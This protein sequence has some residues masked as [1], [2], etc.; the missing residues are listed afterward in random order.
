MD[1]IRETFFQ[2]CEEQ[3]D[4]LERGLLAMQEGSTDSET[5]NAVFR[6]VH[7]IRGGAGAFQL[8]SLVRFAHSFETTLDMIRNERLAPS[9]AVM[10]TMLRAADVLADLVTEARGSGDVDPARS[11]EIIA[12]LTGHTGSA[13]HEPS[14]DA[15]SSANPFAQLGFNPVALSFDSPDERARAKRV[16]ALQTNFRRW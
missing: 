10:R 14:A 4:E 6:A 15:S 1:V 8:N 13:G 16:G 9:Q 3:V 7:P 5:V 2:D 12:E 11:A